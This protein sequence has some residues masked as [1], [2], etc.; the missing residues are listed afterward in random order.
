M[1][2]LF[3]RNDNGRGFKPTAHGQV[4]LRV[5]DVLSGITAAWFFGTLLMTGSAPAW[6]YMLVA[7]FFIAPMLIMIFFSGRG[8]I[9]ALL[10]YA[11]LMRDRRRS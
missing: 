6:L 5:W 3:V 10:H 9:G 1:S 2:A 8:P 11:R 7:P 4:L